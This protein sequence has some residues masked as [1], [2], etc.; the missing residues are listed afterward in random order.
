M[1]ALKLKPGNRPRV[2]KGHP[3]VFA[4]EIQQPLGTDY[5]GR[6]VECRDSQGR[7]LG[8]GIYNEQSQIIWRKFS[9][10]RAP[11]NRD[12]FHAAISA[13]LQRRSN[14]KL[15]RLVWSESD[16]IPGL[17][18]DRY[19]DIIV[20]QALTLAVDKHIA[21]IAEIFDEL[22]KPE[23]ILLKNDAP[24]RSK[25]GLELTVSV[26]GEDVQ[27]HWCQIGEVEFWLD[28]AGGQKT[29]FYLDQ[30]EEYRKI[31]E[32]CAGKR[33]LDAFCNQ[34]GF[35]LHA[36]KHQ[37]SEVFGVDISKDAVEL[38][39][40]NADHN[41]LEATFNAENVFDYFSRERKKQW[42]VI[43]LDPPSFTKSKD[44]LSEAMRG[45]KELNLRALQRLAPGGVLATYSCSHHV[46]HDVYWDMLTDA[47]GDA[48]RTVRLKEIC[49]QP[50]DHPILLNVPESEYLR[51]FILEVL[52]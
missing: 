51:G 27:P 3:W 11:F 49:R 18:A 17:I 26:A 44:R 12:Y 28:L 24:I 34:G 29:G 15:Q 47:A 14:D 8:S 9:A 25:E 52:E 48:G 7:L 5:N 30:R 13:A 22:L 50:A 23:S 40:R 46:T 10:G 32:L 45:Y 38:A 31:A 20:L 43:I 35:A 37:A 39:Q 16:F 4:N 1:P 19:N 33:V 21:E 2:L 36:A 42:D 41:K 6:A